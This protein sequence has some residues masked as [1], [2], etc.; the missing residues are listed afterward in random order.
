MMQIGDLIAT[1]TD[2]QTVDN[3][4]DPT[5]LGN[6][7]G[8][9]T[10]SGS[11]IAGYTYGLGLVSQVTPSGT[12]YYQFGSLGSTADL[13]NATNGVVA[14]YSYLPF[15][16][17]LA[18]KGSVPIPS[19]SWDD[20]RC[21]QMGA[22][23]TKCGREATTLRQGSS[24]RTIPASLEGIQTCEDM[25]GNDPV[26]GLDPTGH[27][28]EGGVE[29]PW[30]ITPPNVIKANL[31]NYGRIAS[32][33]NQLVSPQPPAGSG[34]GAGHGGTGTATGEDPN[35]LLGP[36][37]YGSQ[38]FVASGAPLSYQIDFE[39]SPT[40]TAPA[41]Q[42]VITDTLDPNLDLSTFQ[43]TGINF[44]DT[45][46]TIPP[47]SQDYQTTDPMTYNGVTFDVVINASLDYQTRQLTVTFQSID[48]S[49]QLPPSVLTGFLPP[50]DGTGRG[51][52]YV[53]YFD[54]AQ[55]RAWPPARRSATWPTSCST[56]TRRS[57]P[58]R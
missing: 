27:F 9:Y 26:N 20:T 54:L 46:L 28:D 8:Q 39:N 15:G 1:T 7:V 5:G 16:G 43:L 12:N 52:G 33:M 45:V 40:A 2:G 42:V 32:V 31:H 36:A 38:N 4:I 47:G 29:I 50:E 24:L 48:P 21:L 22:G 10:S 19:R 57:P 14:S 34:N 17:L 37:G 23:R 25:F 3:L 18:S 56:A 41:Q 53:S 30:P 13:T 51:E 11:L 55:C 44:G 58:T 6:L 49:T 35:S